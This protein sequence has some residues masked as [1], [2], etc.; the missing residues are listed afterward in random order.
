[1]SLCVKTNRSKCSRLYVED[2]SA[3]G[4]ATVTALAGSS[5][6][7][8]IKDSMECLSEPCFEKLLHES[9][10]KAVPLKGIRFEA[11]GAVCEVPRSEKNPAFIYQK[12][13]RAVQNHE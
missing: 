9:F 10:Q 11:N 2:F 1:M 4:I 6:K 8:L 5:V 13:L 12:W 7:E 3:D